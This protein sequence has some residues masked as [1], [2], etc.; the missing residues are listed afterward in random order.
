MRVYVNV[1][2]VYSEPMASGV[3]ATMEIASLPGRQFTG[4]VARTNNAIGISSRTLLTEVDVPNPKGELVPGGYAQV[5][6]HLSL[7]T[8]PLVLPGNTILFQAEG[9]Q[10]SVVNSQ[11]RVDLRKV[12]LGRDFGNTIEILSGISQTDAVIANP[13]D[14]LVNGMPVAVQTAQAGGKQE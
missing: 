13:P 9:P 7:K 1:P 11:N 12:T 4:T 6:F 3:K 2:E 10:V 14:Y 5:H 8:V